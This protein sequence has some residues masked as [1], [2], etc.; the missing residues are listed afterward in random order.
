MVRTKPRGKVSRVLRQCYLKMRRAAKLTVM[1]V[2]S[3]EMAFS[4]L[5]K[6]AED[7][8]SQFAYKP[9]S[10]MVSD[11]RPV[12]LVS[13]FLYFNSIERVGH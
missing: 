3:H 1:M 7:F 4:Q 2:M 11:S 13:R 12:C 10:L 5:Q 8:M 6:P 9:A